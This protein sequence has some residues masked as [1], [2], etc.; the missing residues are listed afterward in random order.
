MFFPTSRL[1]KTLQLL[2]GDKNID[3]EDREYF[4]TEVRDKIVR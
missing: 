4:L 2:S 1:K 3:S